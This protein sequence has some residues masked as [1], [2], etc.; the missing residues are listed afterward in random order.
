MS[1]NGCQQKSKY[2]PTYKC[3]GSAYHDEHCIVHDRDNGKVLYALE[4]KI[5][6]RIDTEGLEIDLPGCYFSK[7]F[8]PDYFQRLFYG[9]FAKK[10]AVT[11]PP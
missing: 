4:A 2:D 5:K 8:A 3:G 6:E 11:C 1:D 10:H 7:D 9:D